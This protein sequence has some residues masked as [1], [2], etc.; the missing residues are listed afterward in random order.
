VA[1]A[2]AV[3][4]VGELDFEREVLERSFDVPVVVDFWAPWCGPCRTLGPVLERL[5]A[6][7]AGAFVL[8]KVDVDAAPAVA[9]AFAV[10]SIPAVKGFRDGGVVAEF[11]GAQ[12]EGAVRAFLDMLLPTEADRLARAGEARAEAGDTAGAAAAFEEALARDGRHARALV[13]L[14]RLRAVDQPAV[15]LALLDR[16]PAQ[17]PLAQAAQRLAAELR[18]RLE[19]TGE[20]PAL[21]A[22]LQ[23]N[24]GDLEARLML[25]RVLAASGRYEDALAELLEVVRRDRTFADEGARKAMLDVFDVLGAGNPLADRYRSELARVLFS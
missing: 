21:R 1:E 22:R 9:D 16:V 25:G 3:V 14:A 2:P 6:E 17:V 24:A 23:A 20:E 13:G 18:V 12:P 8:A 5:A 11:V 10:R 15:A 7:H 4:D 19:A